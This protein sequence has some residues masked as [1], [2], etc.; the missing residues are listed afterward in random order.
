MLL[1]SACATPYAPIPYDRA[2][3]GVNRIV[4]IE[5]SFPE[6]ATTQKLA[7]NG[8]NMASAMAANAG[9]AGVLIGA[10]AAGVEANI[11]AGQRKRILAVL[12]SQGFDGEAI[13]DAAL[14]DALS[15]AGYEL[16]TVQIDRKDALTLAIITP[17]PD[18]PAG[19]AVLDVAGSG[20]GYQ[21][22]G[23]NTQWRPFAAAQVRL[24][25]HQNPE[26]ILMDNRV[27]YNPVAQPEVIITIPPG[28]AYAFNKVEDIEADPERAAEGL[29]AAL[30]ETAKAVA[31]LLQ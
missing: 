30:T 4:V 28:E 18:A 24:S 25:D 3:S 7:T 2:S 31:L 20:Y 27:V 13:F 8:E 23:G 5:T 1:V 17:N 26:T 22:V 12:D 14:E 29:K 15:G 16:D 11:E 9:L 19:S 10:V 21:L 6:T